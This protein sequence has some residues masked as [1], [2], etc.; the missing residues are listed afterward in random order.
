VL[1]QGPERGDCD[2]TGR[3]RPGGADGDGIDPLM[4][5]DTRSGAGYEA[6]TLGWA[7]GQRGRH[8]AL[9]KRRHIALGFTFLLCT[10]AHFGFDP[11]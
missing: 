9:R 5:Q 6:F 3:Q 7:S 4:A 2:P 10:L 11:C 8:S 1:S